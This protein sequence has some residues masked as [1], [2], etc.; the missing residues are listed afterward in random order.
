MTYPFSAPSSSR[1]KPRKKKVQLLVSSCQLT[2]VM[3]PDHPHLYTPHPAPLPLILRPGARP[4]ALMMPYWSR[5]IAMISSFGFSLIG[6]G[7]PV[8]FSAISV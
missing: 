4:H 2:F 3:I 7:A 8:I 6:T 1:A 5:R